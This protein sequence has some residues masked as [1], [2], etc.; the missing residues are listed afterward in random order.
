MPRLI[1]IRV[2]TGEGLRRGKRGRRA[3]WRRHVEQHRDFRVVVFVDE[4]RVGLAV[5]VD[6]GDS[7]RRKNGGA[8]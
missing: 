4:D 1:V 2:A 6:F 8:R 5:R 3:A 7:N